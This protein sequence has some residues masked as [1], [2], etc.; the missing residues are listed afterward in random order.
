[1]R[2]APIRVYW[3]REEGEEL[4][5][6]DAYNIEAAEHMRD[7]LKEAGFIDIDIIIRGKEL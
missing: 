4:S 1:M 5:Y 3:R 6:D 7:E 2:E